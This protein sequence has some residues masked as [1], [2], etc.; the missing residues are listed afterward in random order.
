[1]SVLHGPPRLPASSKARRSHTLVPPPPRPPVPRSAGGYLLQ[2][3]VAQLLLVMAS[4]QLYSP[5]ARGHLGEHPYL[6][7]LMQVGEARAVPA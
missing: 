4:T 1:M 5:L 7:A 2:L 6:E 3:E